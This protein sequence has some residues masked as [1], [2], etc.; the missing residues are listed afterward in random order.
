MYADTVQPIALLFAG[1]S[2]TTIGNRISD[3][4]SPWASALS[5]PLL[6]ADKL[7]HD[8]GSSDWLRHGRRARCD[9]S[10]D[11]A[12]A[13]AAKEAHA[14]RICS[15]MRF[16]CWRWGVSYEDPLRAAVVLFI[17][18]RAARN[19]LVLLTP[20]CRTEVSH[21]RFSC[22]GWNEPQQPRDDRSG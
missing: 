21:R 15:R 1:S 6:D 16:S 20:R 14:E 22:I 2:T 4:T 7:S 11:F 10:L 18:R 12:R 3:V 17:M 9:F 8:R 19:P 5:V 13:M